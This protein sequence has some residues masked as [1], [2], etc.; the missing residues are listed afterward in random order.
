MKSPKIIIL[1]LVVVLV[2]FAGWTYYT[3]TM[4]VPKKAEAACR[5]KIDSEVIPAVS[6]EATAKCTQAVQQA[7]QQ[8]VGSYAQ[9]LQMLAQI[10]ACAA[11]MPK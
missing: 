10:P 9:L 5:A 6:A 4:S 3:L 2:A 8:T 1:I 11:V 7:V